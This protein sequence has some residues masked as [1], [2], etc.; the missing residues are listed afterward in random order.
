MTQRSQTTGTHRSRRPKPAK[1]PSSTKH[2]QAAG[3]LAKPAANRAAR[4]G[5]KGQPDA[6][7]VIER[8]AATPAHP[9]FTA[10]PG[11]RTRAADLVFESLSRAILSGAVAP[12]SELPPQRELSVQ[13]DVSPLVVRQAMHR[14]EDLGLLRV[15]QGGATTVLDPSHSADLRLL[16]LRFALAKPG[17]ALALAALE[18]QGLS[19]LQMLVLCQRRITEAEIVQLERLVD[20]LKEG[21]PFREALRFRLKFSDLLSRATRNP[22]L[23][24]NVRWWAAV[25][26]DV[27]SRTEGGDPTSSPRVIAKSFYHGLIKALR[28]RRGAPEHWLKMLRTSF[29]WSEAQPTHPMQSKQASVKGR[30]R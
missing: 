14:L 15:R 17:D 19:M 22:L 5:A 25:M 8:E 6:E 12:G 16:Q 7:Q 28:E 26:T 3:E 20:E 30:S 18:A 13:F 10:H 2:Q 9:G 21:Q 24:Q 29:E 23:V 11:T 1:Q 27:E 4:R